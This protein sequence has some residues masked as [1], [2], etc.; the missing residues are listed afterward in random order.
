M[1]RSNDWSTVVE[2][3]ASLEERE[4]R[5][6]VARDYLWASELSKSPID[7]FLRMRGVRETNPPN[8]RSKRKFEAGNYMEW[9]V[10]L[11]FIRAGIM[12]AQ[13]KRIEHQYEGLLKVSGKLDFLVGGIPDFTE[14]E[15]L[16][17]LMRELQVPEFIFRTSRA[18]RESLV[19]KYPDGL[20]ERI[21]E[22]KSCSSMMFDAMEKKNWVGQAGHRKQLFHYLVGDNR[23]RGDILYLDKD[24]LRMAEVRV[25][26]P[27]AVEEEYRSTIETFTKYYNA[28]KDTPLEQFIEEVEEEGVKSFKFHWQEGLPNIEPLIVFNEDMGKF[29]K[30][31]N[32]E[33]SGYLTPLYGYEQPSEYDDAVKP[34]VARWNRVV[35]RVRTGMARL[36]WLADQG[37]TEED[38]K[39]EMVVIEGKKNRKKVA[40][41][42]AI[43]NGE[44]T[45]VPDEFMRG[46]EMTADNLKVLEEIAQNGFDINEIVKNFVEVEE[47]E[48]DV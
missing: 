9:L 24:S 39:T 37:C 43:E 33:Y 44:K 25:E 16:E 42:T 15:R 38:V 1:N 48:E 8:G 45:F 41:I 3:N 17:A 10:S 14:W 28:H 7:I 19:K 13:Q 36:A 12:L 27:G 46:Y 30:N 35:M 2:W 22:V 23:P 18:I 47:E 5:E 26:N 20:G 31:F 4:E 11:V 32:V 21:I 6:P 29:S 34:I 40:F